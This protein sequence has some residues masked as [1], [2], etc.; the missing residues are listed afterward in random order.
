MADS[1]ENQAIARE[2]SACILVV[3]RAKF[4]ADM[5]LHYYYV[6][7]SIYGWHW[8]RHGDESQH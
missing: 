8:C 3:C 1:A 7:I 2:Y 5:S 4:D 6:A